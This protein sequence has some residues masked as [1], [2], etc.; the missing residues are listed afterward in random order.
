[1]SS[2]VYKKYIPL[3]LRGF[4]TLPSFLSSPSSFATAIF[5]FLSVCILLGS[6]QPSSFGRAR[7]RTA[8]SQRG[9]G[10]LLFLRNSSFWIK[11]QGSRATGERAVKKQANPRW[12]RKGRGLV[13][14]HHAVIGRTSCSIPPLWLVYS[15]WLVNG[16][17]SSA[18]IRRRPCP[19]TVIT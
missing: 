18:V 17:K 5:F 2:V 16:I 8:G 15:V 13:G 3:L 19:W 12:L 11:N 4:Y 9:R 14:H 7:F 6:S 10:R 1:M